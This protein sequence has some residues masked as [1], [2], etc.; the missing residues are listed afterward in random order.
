MRNRAVVS[1]ARDEALTMEVCR[2]A[3]ITAVA[4]GPEVAVPSPG[5]PP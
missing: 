3:H 1:L 2:L 5:T 4:A